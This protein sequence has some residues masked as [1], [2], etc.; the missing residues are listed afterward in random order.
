MNVQVNPATTPVASGVQSPPNPRTLAETGINIIMLRDLLLK[1][2]FRTNL[3]LVS[4]LSKSI[5]LQVPLI[6]E[7]LTSPAPSA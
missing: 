6:Q 5:C 3:D 4:A 1:T 7:L 2:M